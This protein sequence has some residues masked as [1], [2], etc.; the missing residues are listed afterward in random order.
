MDD[1]RAGNQQARLLGT[2]WEM[3]FDQRVEV[4]VH[5]TNR[6]AIESVESIQGIIPR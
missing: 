4:G 5:P 1:G 2:R 3:R 6:A